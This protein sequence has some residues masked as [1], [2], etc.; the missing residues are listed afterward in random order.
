MHV[1]GPGYDELKSYVHKLNKQL[2]KS[3]TFKSVENK[4]IM[5]VVC[6]KGPSIDTI[7]QAKAFIYCSS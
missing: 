2:S 5:Q 3:E 7:M 4:T 6:S 1:Y